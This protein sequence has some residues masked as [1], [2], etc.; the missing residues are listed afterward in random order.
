MGEVDTDELTPSKKN[1][2]EF[3]FNDVSEM[4]KSNDKSST[5]YDTKFIDDDDMNYDPEM[6]KTNNNTQHSEQI[7]KDVNETQ[8][9]SI[10]SESKEYDDSND[11][12]EEMDNSLEDST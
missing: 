2:E 5:R 4:D 3:K 9:Q 8:E 10:Q 7:E 11:W 1:P 6:V 12:K